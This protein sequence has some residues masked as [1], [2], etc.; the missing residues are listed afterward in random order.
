L[1]RTLSRTSYKTESLLT[2]KRLASLCGS[3]IADCDYGIL[4]V[5]GE[6]FQKQTQ[7]DGTSV[8]I[9]L[10]GLVMLQSYSNVSGAP[11][12]MATYDR[13]QKA[14]VGML[15]LLSYGEVS[16]VLVRP[17]DLSDSEY[18]VKLAK[19]KDLVVAQESLKQPLP[20]TRELFNIESILTNQGNRP[21]QFGCLQT[22]L[23]A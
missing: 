8:D 22:C 7:A 19:F 3:P 14:A 20:A 5:M 9:P 13:L 11:V 10:H 4:P 12:N 16:G 15:I 6:C 17:N 2:A 23:N 18:K 1:A 21:G